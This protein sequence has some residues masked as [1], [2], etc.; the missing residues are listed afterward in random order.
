MKKLL[1][2]GASGLLGMNLALGLSKKY[3]IFGV[4]NHLTLKGI[5]FEMIQ[6]DF[7]RKDVAA[8]LIDTV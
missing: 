6:R 7:F 1:V 3:R 2:T 4:A 8:E 5:P